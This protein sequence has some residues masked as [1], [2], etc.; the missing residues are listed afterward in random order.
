MNTLSPVFGE[1]QKKKKKSLNIK[2]LNLENGERKQKRA[3]AVCV[4]LDSAL[5]ANGKKLKWKV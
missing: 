4:R 1:N 5:F 3:F 2:D